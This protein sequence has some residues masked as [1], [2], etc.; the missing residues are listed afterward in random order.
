MYT[1][2]LI[3]L[4]L[5]NNDTDSYS[6]NFI[7]LYARLISVYISLNDLHMHPGLNLSLHVSQ[8]HSLSPILTG[9]NP[10]HI[11]IHFMKFSAVYFSLSLSYL[12]SNFGIHKFRNSL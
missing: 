9:L 5:E 3:Y 4:V 1:F 12:L 7:H 11:L 8:N 6:C 10:V 2:R